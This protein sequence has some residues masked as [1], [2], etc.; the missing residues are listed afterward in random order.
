MSCPARRN[1]SGFTLIE[2]VVVVMILGILAA[3]AAPKMLHTS[4]SAIDNGLRQSLGVVR[5][6]IDTYAA[7]HLGN[8]PG[9]DGDELTFQADILP[10]LRGIQFPTCPA[11]QAKN[12]HVRMM[13]GNGAITT[14]IGAT[15]ATHSWV[16]QYEVGDFFVNST[17]TASDGAT[18]YDKF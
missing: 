14:G 13:S 1:R 4:E 18:T 3:I 10:Y 11:G 15:A 2:L 17:D 9:A 12:N 7:Q 16:Y 8:L 5:T 6:A